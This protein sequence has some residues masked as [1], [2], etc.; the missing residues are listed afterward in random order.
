MEILGNY[1]LNV[2]YLPDWELVQAD[3]LSRIY[4]QNSKSEGELD[5]DWPIIYAHG[6]KGIYPSNLS[7]KTLETVIANKQL[8]RVDNGN[9][10]R[11]VDNNVWVTYIS[12][13]QRIETILRYHRDL[14]H[15][16]FII[17]YFS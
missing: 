16:R 11:K 3:A 17:S 12:T 2:T 8:F 6:E 10:L 1:N 5:P 13:S 14:G 7:P 15:T 9:I 4:I